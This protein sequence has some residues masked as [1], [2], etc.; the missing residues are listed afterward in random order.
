MVLA[1]QSSTLLVPGLD[2]K[3]PTNSV[4]L[5]ELLGVHLLH[6]LAFL[7]QVSGLAAGYLFTAFPELMKFVARCEYQV[8]RVLREQGI[9]F[10]AKHRWKLA[11]SNFSRS[12]S[13][14]KW[15]SPPKKKSD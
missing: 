15:Y 7:T 5:V 11:I 9:K 12:F 10:P 2:K 13:D 8:D 14:S 3:V 1:H 4:I 6:P